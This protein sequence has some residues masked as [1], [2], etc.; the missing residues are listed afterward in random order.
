MEPNILTRYER[1]KQRTRE[2]LKAAAV[3][4]LVEKGYEALTIQD[5]TDHLDVARATFYI[6]FRD[7]D[8]IVWAVLQDHFDVLSS[9]IQKLP[10]AD[11]T[12][13][14]RQKLLVLFEHA[15]THKAL[16][17]VLLSERGHV[18]LMRRFA[19]YVADII[20][21]DIA[22]GLKLTDPAVSAGFAAQFLAGALVQVL[23]WWLIRGAD[24]PPTHM[25]EMFLRVEAG[26]GT[27]AR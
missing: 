19:E 25:A 24:V 6:Y 23:T 11:P 17:Q 18:K 15:S 12:A 1:R 22:S 16:L 3:A 10:Q 14:H 27:E 21:A 2:M 26:G 7:K 8:D 5:V 13:R 20:Q 9:I 4:L